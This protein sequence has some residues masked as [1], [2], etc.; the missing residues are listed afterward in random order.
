MA[1]T[2]SNPQERVAREL[3]TQSPGLFVGVDGD[4]CAHY[5]DSYERAVAAV[6]RGACLVDGAEKF[7]L[8]QTPCRTL[9]DWCE[10]V[11]GQRGW[12]VGPRVGG[13]LVGDLVRGF[14]R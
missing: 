9:A 5:W 13:S 14:E 8:A 7:E 3:L 11:R 4:G 12:A 10:H 6:P 1:T 2:Q